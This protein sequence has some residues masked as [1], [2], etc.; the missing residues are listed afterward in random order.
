MDSNPGSILN[1]PRDL[2]QMPRLGCP[3]LLGCSPNDITSHAGP[4]SPR[5]P[6]APFG[7]RNPRQRDL[8]ALT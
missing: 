7:H 3:S 6:G 8:S 1:L 5:P 4:F 2:G